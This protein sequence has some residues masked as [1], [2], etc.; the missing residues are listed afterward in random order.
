[1]EARNYLPNDHPYRDSKTRVQWQTEH[2]AVNAGAIGERFWHNRFCQAAGIYYRKEDTHPAS[3]EELFGWAEEKRKDA[4][5]RY[6]KRKEE[7]QRLI[8][9]EQERIAALSLAK[10]KER[11]Y[12]LKLRSLDPLK[13]LCIDTETTGLYPGVDELLQISIINGNGESVFEHYVKPKLHTSWEEAEEINGISP[14]M[15]DEEEDIDSYRE[16]LNEV[17]SKAE[18]IV[19]YNNW[20]DLE[21]LKAAGI[22][23]PDKTDTFDVMLEFAPIYGMW[24]LKRNTYRWQKLTT[25]AAYYG[26]QQSNRYHDSLEDARATLYCFYKMIEETE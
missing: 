3:E 7:K 15:V 4:R 10:E 8:R 25:C 5:D 24:D 2:R 13:I 19:G 18:L 20:F 12:H 9:E 22:T 14:S 6:A 23:V 26:Y 11:Q 21:F 1:M 16:Q 17:L